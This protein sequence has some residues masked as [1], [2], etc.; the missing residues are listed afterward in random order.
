[1]KKEGA[2]GLWPDG[3]REYSTFESQ[4]MINE[5]GILLLLGRITYIDAKNHRTRSSVS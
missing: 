5:Y 2:A 1:M 3:T 4:P